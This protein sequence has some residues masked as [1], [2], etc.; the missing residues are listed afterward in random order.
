MSSQ[1]NLVDMLFFKKFCE[2][3]SLSCCKVSSIKHKI[4]F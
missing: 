4:I 3:E 2:Q 1:E